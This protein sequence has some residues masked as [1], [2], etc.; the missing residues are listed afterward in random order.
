MPHEDISNFYFNKLNITDDII[1][2]KVLLQIED[3]NLEDFYLNLAIEIDRNHRG[4][5][6][7]Y[8]K[9]TLKRL[10]II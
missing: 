4:T 10:G 8:I 7:K 2:A 6:K 5:L 1:K 3:L 9:D